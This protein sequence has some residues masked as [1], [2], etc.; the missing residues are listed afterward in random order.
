MVK[1]LVSLVVVMGIGAG[2]YFYARGDASNRVKA[3]MLEGINMM[4]LSPD[5][6]EYVRQQFEAVH[7]AA[8]DKALKA[9][10]NAGGTSDGQLYYDAT[11]RG[12]LNRATSVG[13]NELVETLTE[14]F[15]L[16]KFNVEER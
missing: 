11:E 4:Q 1:R 16:L 15:E 2:V 10:A 6:A 12:I 9:T 13:R 3:T 8:F 7:P 5:D 14:D